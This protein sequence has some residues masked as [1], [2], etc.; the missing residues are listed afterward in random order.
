MANLGWEEIK[1]PNPVF[2]GDTLYCETEVLSKR[3]SSSYPEAGIVRVC[4][5]GINQDGMIVIDLA[6][7]IMIYKRDC[8]PKKELFPKIKEN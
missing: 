4:S 5:R 7:A 2:I 8:D 6:R 3:E 1:L